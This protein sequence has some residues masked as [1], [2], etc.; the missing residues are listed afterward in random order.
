MPLFDRVAQLFDEVELLLAAVDVLVVEDVRDVA[1]LGAVHRGVGAPHESGAFGGVL[2]RERDADAR[3]D[4]GAHLLQVE[5][6]DDLG[7]DVVRPPRR[8]ASASASTS[9]TANSSPPSR[10]TEPVSGTARMSRGPS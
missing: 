4:A 5:R 7:D 9:S 2:G 8:R 6:F 1:Q 3:A 10:K